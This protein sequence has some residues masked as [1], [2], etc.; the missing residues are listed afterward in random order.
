MVDLGARTDPA[1]RQS[2]IGVIADAHGN[3]PA[4]RAILDRLAAAGCGRIVH[5]GDAV[6]IG[7]HPREV[8]S[9]LARR[10]VT[11]IMG[12]HDELAI[13]GLPEPPPRHM[14]GAE[15][16]NHRWVRAQL[17]ATDR[18]AMKAWP[19]ALTVYVGGTPV[20]VLHY[21]RDRDARFAGVCD[22]TGPHFARRF[23]DVDAPLVVFGHDHRPHDLR[24]DG[25]R[26]LDP[27]SVG[28]HDRPVARALVLE[29]ARAGV[30]VS[31]LEIA[32]DA[33]SVVRDLREREVPD[34]DL[35]GRSFMPYGRIGVQSA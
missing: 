25:R 10:A 27:G 29:R 3:L 14:S 26:F 33:S 9:L 22:P 24:I 16:A 2:R 23:A 28:C 18:E 35:I 30:T 21:P 20:V 1:G 32:Y 11:C 13:R 4:T 17:T 7:P 12:N 5:A 34:G 19:Y 31:R 8:V 6:G 15:V